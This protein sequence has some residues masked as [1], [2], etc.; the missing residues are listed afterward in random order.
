[1]SRHVYYQSKDSCVAEDFPFL[2]TKIG[3]AWPE[4]TAFDWRCP[5]LSEGRNT[6]RAHPPRSA[7]RSAVAPSLT[8][9][10]DEACTPRRWALPVPWHEPHQNW[11]P[12]DTLAY[13][14]LLSP[15]GKILWSCH[16]GNIWEETNLHINNTDKYIIIDRYSLKTRRKDKTPLCRTSTTILMDLWRALSNSV[17]GRLNRESAKPP[18]RTLF[19]SRLWRHKGTKHWTSLERIEWNLE[20]IE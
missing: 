9:D 17:L 13:R 2:V 11:V 3:L 20:R 4:D 10:T 8:E 5:D 18:S 6:C 14:W 1:M 12:A 16:F 15:T 7:P 19:P